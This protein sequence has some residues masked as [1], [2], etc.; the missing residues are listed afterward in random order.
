MN[1]TNG[2]DKTHETIQ[3]FLNKFGQKANTDRFDFSFKSH[4]DVFSPETQIPDFWSKTRQQFDKNSC[5]FIETG[6]VLPKPNLFPK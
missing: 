6:N 5:F 2:T 3:N 4:P 1:I